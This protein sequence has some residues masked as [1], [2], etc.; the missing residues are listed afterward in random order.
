MV[1]ER[2]PT[3]LPQAEFL[4]VIALLPVVDQEIETE[5]P[6]VA[7]LIVPPEVVQVQPVLFAVQPLAEALKLRP[8]SGVPVAGPV[9]V[10]VGSVGGGLPPT[11]TV[12]VTSLVQMLKGGQDES[13][14][15]A[16][17]NVT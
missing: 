14:V 15:R 7:P 4:A 11:V 6:L 9:T 2:L 12:F 10:I 13:L 3:A 16:T 8:W 17:S 1:T 5:E